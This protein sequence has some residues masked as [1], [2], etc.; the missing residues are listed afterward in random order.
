MR[1]GNLNPFLP[2]LVAHLPTAEQV[3]RHAP[4]R[5]NRGLSYLDDLENTDSVVLVTSEEE[6][7]VSR[8]LDRSA[9]GVGRVL[10]HTG[11][12]GLE[13]VND[14]LRLEVKDLDAARGGSTEPVSVGREAESVDSVTGLERVEVLAVRELPKHGDTVLATGGAE[15][16]IGRNGDGVDVAGVAVVVGLQ[17]ALAELPNLQQIE[18]RRNFDV[19]VVQF[20]FSET[21]C[22]SFPFFLPRSR[23]SNNDG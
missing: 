14:A 12:L 13:L 16:A 11:E 2:P 7:A 1:T 6:A 9:L 15:R 8:P 3:K 4:S 18:R 17:L 20:L 10:A 22:P 5:V 19:S 21:V 23:H